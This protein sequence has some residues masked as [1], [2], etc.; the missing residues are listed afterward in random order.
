MDGTYTEFLQEDW[1]RQPWNDVVFA[2]SYA[3]GMVQEPQNYALQDQNYEGGRRYMA[4]DAGYG[5]YSYG[6]SSGSLDGHTHL[7]SYPPPVSYPASSIIP[8]D[9]AYSEQSQMPLQ[10]QIEPQTNYQQM[11]PSEYLQTTYPPAPKYASPEL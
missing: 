6:S 3:H 8:P 1:D 9:P 7:N 4:Q 11:P 10:S 2:P 5:S